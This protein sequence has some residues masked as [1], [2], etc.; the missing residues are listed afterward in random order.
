MYVMIKSMER[1]LLLGVLLGVGGIFLG[2]LIEGGEGFALIQGAAFLIV[3]AGTFGAVIVGGGFQTLREGWRWFRKALSGYEPP[4]E[5][6]MNEILE[7]AKIAKKESLLA[8]EPRL[9]GLK[10][11]FLKDVMTTTIDN[12]EPRLLMEIF[13]TRIQVEKQ[14]LQEGSKMWLEAGGY[15]PTI[16]IIG[17]VLGLIHVMSNLSDTSKLGPG[18]AIAFVATIYGVGFANLI[19]LPIGSRI[20]AMAQ[21]EILLKQMMVHGGLGILQGL[22]PTILEIKLRSFL[23]EPK[24]QGIRVAQ[25][26][27]TV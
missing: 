6:I 13:E 9:T 2:H 5:Q 10:D 25:E 8:I 24:I 7:L 19:F 23:S 3:F 26:A 14:K 21:K 4:F 20:Q 17:A 18:I 27:P 22:N 12:L 1:S 15:S 11:P 16:G